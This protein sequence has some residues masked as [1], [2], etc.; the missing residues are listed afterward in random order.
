MNTPSRQVPRL[1][2]VEPSNP[3]SSYIVH[4]LDVGGTGERMP[5]VGEAEEGLTFRI[6][7]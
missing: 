2:R 1:N 5:K 3:D 7:R 4:K 6:K